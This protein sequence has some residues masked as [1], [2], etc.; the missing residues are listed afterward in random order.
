MIRI[1]ALLCF[2]LAG[3]YG[4]EDAL[5]QRVQNRVQ[6]VME[7][8]TSG[9]ATEGLDGLLK[10]AGTLDP[11]QA[12][13]VKE[14]NQDRESIFQLI[15]EKTRV[16]LDDVRQMYVARARTKTP[17]LAAG[18]NKC[19][20]AP[21]KQVDVARLLQYLKQGISYARQRQFD[22]ALAE[23]Q[24]ALTIDKNFLALS[25]NVGA[26]QLGLGK[27]AEAEEAFR[28]ELK[29]VDCLTGMQDAQL[30]SFGYFFEVEEKEP[31][32]RRKAQADRLKAELPRAK[33]AGHFNLACALSRQKKTA[34]AL[35]ELRASLDAGFK[36]RKALQSEPDL[37]LVRQ[38]PEYREIAGRLP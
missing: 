27:L 6:A 34:E 15:A 18:N 12:Q 20:L 21:A 25:Q 32:K 26:A 14:E 11:S 28:A 22:L 5:K 29:L 3:L 1:V 31:A 35:A 24:P 7:L 4:Q 16:P 30:A 9:T 2:A 33:A 10:P 23:F 17:T 8:L 36:D 19:K 38:S 37:A 13:L